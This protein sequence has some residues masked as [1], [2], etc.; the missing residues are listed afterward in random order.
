M[1]KKPPLKLEV[2]KQKESR[3]KYSQL[4]SSCITNH[5]GVS[6]GKK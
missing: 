4:V 2:E 6:R 5:K 3:E 1:Y